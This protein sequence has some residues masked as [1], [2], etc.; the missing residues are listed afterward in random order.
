MMTE[1][2]SRN[3][4]PA[5]VLPPAS[6]C[7]H[8]IT[9]RTST[10]PSKMDLTELES[11][12]CAERALLGAQ[13]HTKLHFLRALLQAGRWVYISLQIHG[14]RK[15]DG[16]SIVH[17]VWGAWLSSP[18]QHRLQPGLMD[19]WCTPRVHLCQRP[20]AFPCNL[21]PCLTIQNFPF[22]FDLATS[23]QGPH[24]FLSK[25][26]SKTYFPSSLAPKDHPFWLSSTCPCHGLPPGRGNLHL[27]NSLL[28]FLHLFPLFCQS[29][30]EV[31]PFLWFYAICKFN[32][33]VFCL[34]SPSTNDGTD[35]S[36]AQD[37]LWH[38]P[39]QHCSS[40]QSI[41]GP[42]YNTQQALNSPYSTKSYDQYLEYFHS[43]F[44]CHLLQLE[45]VFLFM[46]NKRDEGRRQIHIC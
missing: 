21:L 6:P 4:L 18:P 37:T 45:I 13:K 24:S 35:Q 17:V 33:Q 40:W 26:V 42:W 46:R 41:T 3:S 8:T 27:S 7:P 15:G 38:C 11:L 10:C 2:S 12:W 28:A 32:R 31:N 44:E 1:L 36:R 14:E 19:V 22:L 20:T 23:S 34:M 29:H 43:C 5:T 25:I 39:T 9:P 16:K 30:F